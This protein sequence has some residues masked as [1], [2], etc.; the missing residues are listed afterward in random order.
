M[1]VVCMTINNNNIWVTAITV[2]MPI[3]SDQS[4]PL[5]GVPT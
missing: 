5:I 3:T 4:R 2:I 1:Y